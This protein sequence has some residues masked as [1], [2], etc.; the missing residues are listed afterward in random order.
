VTALGQRLKER[1]GLSGPLSVADYMA[2][3]LLDPV[4]GY[5][6]TREPFGTAGDFVTAPEVSQMFGE[7]IAAWLLSAWEECG[8]AAGAVLVELGPG[9]G[10]LMR[11]V[12]R[13][14]RRLDGAW[15]G[16]RPIAMIEASPRLREIQR[17]TLGE[18]TTKATWLDDLEDLPER[19]LLIVANEFFDALPIRQYQKRDGAWRERVIGL[20]GTGELAF[21][22]GP[23]TVDADLLPSGSD[24]QPDETVVEVSP[25]RAAAMAAVARRLRAGGAGLFVDYGHLVPG[26][27]D[28][29]QAVRRHSFESVLANPGEAD[30]T[31]HV[32]FAALAAAAKAHGLAAWAA[33]QGEF[34]LNLGLLERAGALGTGAGAE[35][36]ERLRGEVERLAGPDAMGELFKVLA[37]GQPGST[38]PGL[39]RIG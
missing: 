21:G 1:I 8:R 9:R 29:F 38:L 39:A 33:T 16:R 32:D 18:F 10:T 15:F 6:T 14:L 36:Q 25:A 27:G 11:D 23:G 34:L 24:R 31:A 3:C 7:L 17:E 28:T 22:L 30:L 5:Y 20:D 19:P 2:A 26:F 37:V 35:R 13:T 12:C 4:A